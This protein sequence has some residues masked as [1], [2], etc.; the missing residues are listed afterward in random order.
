MT[1][2]PNFV[3]NDSYPY[4]EHNSSDFPATYY[5]KRCKNPTEYSHYSK[6]FQTEFNHMNNL[7]TLME[8]S[9][10]EEIYSRYF[11][12]YYSTDTDCSGQPYICME[13]IAGNTLEEILTNKNCY[14]IPQRLL[15]HQQI[16]H[17]YEQ[18]HEAI[19]W[20]YQGGML[21]LDLSPQNI[22][23][24]NNNYDIKLIDFTSCYFFKKP[25]GIHKQIDYRFRP[26]VSASIQLRDS[27]A[28]LFTRLFFNGN[29]YYQ[30]YFASQNI[31]KVR[32]NRNY[33]EKQ[34]PQLLNCLFYPE[35]TEYTM[36]DTVTLSYFECWYETL[37]KL[38]CNY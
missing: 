20:L 11:P 26:Q 17:I 23:V 19:Y 38:L 5:Y 32:I 6:L 4:F 34:Y 14:E 12:Y 8:K 1:L 2:N 27:C 30:K 22:L 33:F 35:S 3:P 28:L 29:E 37:R 24:L 10:T 21:Q 25:T 18:L 16:L 31:Y 13:R 7:R 9:G 15:S 36:S